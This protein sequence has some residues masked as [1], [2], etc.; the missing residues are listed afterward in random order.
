MPRRRHHRQRRLHGPFCDQ[1]ELRFFRRDADTRRGRFVADQIEVHRGP[2]DPPEGLPS[3]L[4]SESSTG[5]RVENP[6]RL[7]LVVQTDW[8]AQ[9][10][11]SSDRCYAV[12]VQ[13]RSRTICRLR[14]KTPRREH[15]RNPV[16]LRCGWRLVRR[17][18]E[19]RGRS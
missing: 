13:V 9:H 17:A 6:P 4:L 7:G 8:C 1:D 12:E 16:P 15:R 3:Q 18:E 14:Q 11:V 10:Q 2:N 5:H 19:F